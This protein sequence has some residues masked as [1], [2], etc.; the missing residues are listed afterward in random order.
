MYTTT[1]E[2]ST[3]LD[4]VTLDVLQ[5]GGV[6]E[7]PVDAL[8]LARALKIVVATDDRQQG[9]ARYV[10]L[11]GYRGRE[12]LG[13]ILLR[14][15][16]RRERRHWAVAHEIGEHVAW[17][18]FEELQI[19]PRE[20]A[21]N[22]REAIANHLAGRLLVPTPW[23]AAD[24]VGCRWNLLKLKLRYATASHEL[25]ARRMLDFPPPIIV[26]IFDQGRPTFRRSN[27]YGRVPPPSPVEFECWRAVHDG[28]QPHC[29]ERG[30]LAI[31][32]WPVHEDG[33]KREILR[34]EVNT[35]A[36]EGWNDE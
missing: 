26:T 19:D 2:L 24:A 9:R 29:L 16:P 20:T 17:R 25:L 12:P 31:S 7:P 5:L 22:A 13:T 32:G 30:L 8:E 6:R 28:N 34:T 23:F 18:V 10:R 4:R 27:V 35:E 36:D 1:E 11:A 33:W 21:P 14:P 3:T 15:E